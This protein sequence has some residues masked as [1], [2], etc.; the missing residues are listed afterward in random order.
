MLPSLAGSG[1]LHPI[2][3]RSAPERGPLHPIAELCYRKEPAQSAGEASAT[4][5]SVKRN[6]LQLQVNSGLVS[7]APPQRVENQVA[8]N[9]WRP[10]RC[11]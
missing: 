10:L 2:E 1:N 6:G 7:S 11:L 8:G 4:G 3:G 9:K 5:Q